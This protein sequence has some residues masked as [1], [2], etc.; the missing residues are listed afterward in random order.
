MQQ[1]HLT[2][3]TVHQAHLALLGLDMSV[4]AGTP[5]RPSASLPT[6]CPSSK[7]WPIQCPPEL[8]I[9]HCLGEG[10]RRGRVRGVWLVLALVRKAARA[11]AGCEVQKGKRKY[12]KA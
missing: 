6:A 4:A 8:G 3:A 7:P 11:R 9:K 10:G 12:G 1:L 2:A 5:V